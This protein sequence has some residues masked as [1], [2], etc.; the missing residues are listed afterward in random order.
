MIETIIKNRMALGGL[1]QAKLAE[2]S[3]STPTQIGLFLKG[4][5]FLSKPS[6]EKSLSALGINIDIYEK[7]FQ[8]A[9]KA[10]NKLKNLKVE[11]VLKMSKQEMA[12]KSGI[13]EIVFLFDVSERELDAMVAS[14]IV[15]YEGTFP[16]FKAMVLHLMQIGDRPTPKVVEKSFSNLL[17]ICAES[18]AFALFG[19][20]G[21]FAMAV[22]SLLKNN[23][24]KSFI[25]NAMTPLMAL[26]KQILK[27]TK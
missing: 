7:R 3:G 22:S 12:S 2:I 10:A 1:T 16:F 9:L 4:E 11:E 8:L 25:S 17:G 20:T 5:A 13:Q 14:G 19:V 23:I 15:D 27:I 18:P 24:Y 6:L 26:T 21:I